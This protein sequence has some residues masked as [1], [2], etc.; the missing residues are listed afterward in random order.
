MTRASDRSVL[1]AGDSPEVFSY[2]GRVGDDFL[3]FVRENLKGQET[4]TS[5]GVLGQVIKVLVELVHNVYDHGATKNRRGEVRV[6]FDELGTFVEVSC[7]STNEAA[8]KVRSHVEEL[9][10][11][12]DQELVDR[13]HRRWQD[14]HRGLG[15]YDI[16]RVALPTDNGRAI[17]VGPIEDEIN[18]VLTVRANVG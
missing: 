6:G 15:F 1:L 17:M 12:S 8:A 3:T 10:Q 4:I 16:A 13:A 14:Y 11:L 5:G 18:P 9:R 7:L 2:T